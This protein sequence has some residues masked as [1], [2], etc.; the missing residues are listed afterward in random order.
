MSDQAER[1][2]KLEALRPA[3]GHVAVDAAIAAIRAE[4][5]STMRITTGDDATI[6]KPTVTDIGGD[7]IGSN[8][9]R[10]I[11]IQEGGILQ[12]G[13]TLPNLPPKPEAIQ[14]AISTYLRTLLEQYHFLNLQ[15]VGMAGSQQTRIALRSVFINLHTDQ[16]IPDLQALPTGEAIPTKRRSGEAR[17]AINQAAL[18][19]DLNQWLEEVLTP[20]ERQVLFANHESDDQQIRTL[21][22]R[23]QEPRSALELIR[24]HRALVLLGDPGS[25]K[26]TILRHLAL[27]FAHA[28][29]HAGSADPSALD[30]ELAWTGPLP[31]PILVQLRRFADE[32]QAPPTDAGPLLSF[33]EQTLASGRLDALARHLEMRFE[34]GSILLMCDGLD[35]V[36]DDTRRAWVS[37]AIAHLRNR[38]PLSRIVVTSRT[39]AYRDTNILPVPFQTARLQ[40]LQAAEQDAFIERWYRAALLHT[41]GL[42]SADQEQ[43]AIEKGRDLQAAL[44]RRDRL[45][46]IASNPL[47]LTMIAQVHQHRFRLPQQRAA[48]YN[49]CLQ[50]LLEQWERHNAG[51]RKAGL[52]AMLEIPEQT[53]PAILVQP[54]AYQLQQQGREEAR[55]SELDDWLLPRFLDIVPDRTQAKALIERFLD[56]LEGRSGLLIA[57][58]VKAKYAFP[59]RTFQEYLTAREL[60]YQGLTH[61]REEVLRHRHAT[62]WREVILLTVG[63]LVSSVPQEARALG[64]AILE[65]DL[66]GTEGYYSSVA[67]AGEIAEELEGIPGR[68]G[69]HFKADVIAALVELVQGGHLPARERVAAAMTLGRLGDPRLPTP[70]Q[71]AYW[72]PIEPGS[73]WFGDDREGQPLKQV[74]IMAP[75]KIARYSVTNAEYDRFIKSSGYNLDADWWTASARR[76]IQNRYSPDFWNDQRYCGATQ[77]VIGVMWH[78]AIAYC[79]WLSQQG[80]AQ[81]WLPGTDEIRLPTSLEWERAARHT[82]QRR[83]P[84]GEVDPTAEHANHQ[85]TGIVRTTPVGCFPRGKSECGAQDL[86]GNTFEWLATLSQ[87]AAQTTPV[88]DCK[89]LDRVLVTAS[90]WDDNQTI[91]LSCGARLSYVPNVWSNF[92]GFRVVWFPHSSV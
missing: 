80:H 39:Y 28:R 3:L 77:P 58:D 36:P 91:N 31:L 90:N 88:R 35:E 75:Y 69:Q 10:D 49:E 16:T 92:S 72:C 60:I 46:E 14:H 22:Q 71:P 54:V 4:G 83:Y 62:P 48:L 59:H 47:L 20:A 26:T 32:L 63:H 7:M 52:K 9:L 40:P 43:A 27:S 5:A 66:P 30:P 25:G 56:F 55:K 78:E 82:D 23:L 17:Q 85:V 51:G 2:A 70:D 6:E 44:E 34:A 18:S 74:Q 21:M 86:A 68:E 67:L 19:R 76:Y 61:T 53:D 11:T 50:L 41:S 81:G 33:V 13:G 84:W 65:A 12:I 73:F 45:R 57:R 37:Q 29:L 79:N 38:F 1:I 64:W 89:R 24:H 87:K 8:L 15:G 42:A